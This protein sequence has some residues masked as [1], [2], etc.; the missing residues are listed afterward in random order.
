MKNIKNTLFSLFIL[1]LFPFISNS[2]VGGFPNKKLLE[3]SIDSQFI[4]LNNISRNQDQ[5]K[6]IRRA[7]LDQVRSNVADSLSHYKKELIDLKSQI[8]EHSTVTNNLQDS[9]QNLKAQIQEFEKEKDSIGFLGMQF[10]KTAYSIIVWSIIAVLILIVFVLFQRLISNS[11]TTKEAKSRVDEIQEEF[12]KH[13][14]KALEKEQ[15]LMRQLQ[16]EINK[17]GHF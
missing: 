11:I 3:G 15:K 13:R 7:N 17:K 10:S 12:D 9:I 2:Q 6:L 16:D 5:H 4:E 14:K 1:I 8:A